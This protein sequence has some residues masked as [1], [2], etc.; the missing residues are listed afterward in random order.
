MNIEVNYRLA[1]LVLFLLLLVM[2][3]YFM[4]KVRRSGGRILPKQGAIQREGGRG[5]LVIRIIGFLALMVFLVMYIAGMK[6]IDAF[7]FTLPA[8]YAG[9]DL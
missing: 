7:H 8:G 3:V 6:W 1:F 2:R 5:V 9:L 4:V